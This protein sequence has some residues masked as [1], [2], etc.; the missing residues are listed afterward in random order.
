MEESKMVELERDGLDG[1][2]A[3]PVGLLAETREVELKL[4][5]ELI[6]GI[7]EV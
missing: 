4:V 6:G 5:C 2:V 1:S 3:I 7:V